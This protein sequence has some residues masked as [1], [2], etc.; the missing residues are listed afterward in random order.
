MYMYKKQTD[1]LKC[2]VFD[3]DG[4]LVD[5]SPGIIE[6]IMFALQEQNYPVLSIKR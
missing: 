5:T 2:V 6:S 4:T 3:L 1:F